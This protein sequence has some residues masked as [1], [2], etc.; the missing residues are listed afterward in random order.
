M[1]IIE[2]TKQAFA[3][4]GIKFKRQ[5][6]SEQDFVYCPV[7]YCGDLYDKDFKLAYFS[8]AYLTADDWEIMKEN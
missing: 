5:G 7:K 4:P 2:M 1:N 3:N 8:I 6:A